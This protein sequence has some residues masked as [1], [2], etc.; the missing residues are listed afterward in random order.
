MFSPQMVI[1]CVALV[2]LS[3]HGEVWPKYWRLRDVQCSWQQGFDSDCFDVGMG[4]NLVPLV[5]PKIAGKWM[6]IP[7][8]MVLIGIDPYP[9]YK[10]V[11]HMS[12]HVFVWCASHPELCYSLASSCVDDSATFLRAGA[13]R[14]FLQ[15]AI[16][17]RR[18]VALWGLS[19]R[20]GCP[21]G[22]SIGLFRNCSVRLKNKFVRRL[23]YQSGISMNEAF[24]I[25]Q[26]N[27]KT[28]LVGG[29]KHF[30]CPLYIGCHP[31][32]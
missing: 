22:W 4:Q 2:S 21:V 3:S 10:M 12:L 28:I 6:F 1:N 27:N 26:E 14:I 20:L 7:L 23:P 29:F 15:V 19:G 31:S 32:H 25:L 16:Q 13:A 9:C 17:H 30:Y 8:K 18:T 5:N 24:K 11:S